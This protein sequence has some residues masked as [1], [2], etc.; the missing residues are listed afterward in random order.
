MCVC[1]CVCIYIRNIEIT[2][3][4]LCKKKLNKIKNKEIYIKNT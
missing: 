2:S 3:I 4:L 1:V